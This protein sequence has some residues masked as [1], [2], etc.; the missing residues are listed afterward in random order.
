M[1]FSHLSIHTHFSVADSVVRPDELANA[2][3]ERGISALALTDLGNMF[4]MLKFYKACRQNQIKP[5]LGADLRCDS[6]QDDHGDVDHASRF[7]VL[8][9]NGVGF[10]NLKKLISYSYRDA[11]KLGVI[12]FHKLASYNEGLICLSGGKDGE[13]GRLL[14]DDR[15]LEAR[16]AALRYKEAFGDRFYLEVSRT[17]RRDETRYNHLAVLLADELGIPL[18]AT[19]DVC[20]IKADQHEAHG[21]RIS[22]GNPVLRKDDKWREKYSDQ[23]YL[24]S[25]EEMQQVFADLPDALANAV[26]VA[27]RCNL[28][29]P[30]G[31]VHLP[32][33]TDLEDSAE[34]VLTEKV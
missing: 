27:K 15:E 3:R 23:Q 13:I 25:S 1:T 31:E 16:E 21:A 14:L 8:A 10:I 4:A 33:L 30:T 29:L 7:I 26:E 6:L 24:R 19:N 20:M 28:I 17:G 9:Q 2:A 34:N 11:E 22:I 5:I 12:S 18:I 32:K